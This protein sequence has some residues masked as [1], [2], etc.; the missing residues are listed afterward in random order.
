M[1]NNVNIMGRLT[2]APELRQTQSGTSVA[3]FSLAV[4]RDLKNQD[5]QKE[6]DF[7]DVVAWRQTADFV[8][9]Y[10][11]KGQLVAVNG[12]LQTR[13]W[14]DNN[15]NNRKTVEIVAERAYFAESKRDDAPQTA[16]A[17]PAP[18]PAAPMGYPAP[19]RQAAPMGYSAPQNQTAA[20]SNMGVGYGS[21]NNAPQQPAQSPLPTYSDYGGDGFGE[22]NEDD[23]DLPF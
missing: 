7:F 15:G 10:F 13:T 9:R 16:G 14:Q 3:S 1:L 12:R 5:G 2:R 6:T 8:S 23:G 21:W 4:E 18:M 22:Y 20:P 11:Q 19:H 17:Y